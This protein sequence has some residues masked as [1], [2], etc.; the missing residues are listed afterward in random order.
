[1]KLPEILAMTDAE[2]EQWL[3]DSHVKASEQFR[4]SLFVAG[5]TTTMSLEELK[6]SLLK[7]RLV[8]TSPIFMTEQELRH[9]RKVGHQ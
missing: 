3:E 4:K 8:G 6:E 5:R 2:F 9:L 7:H 1:M